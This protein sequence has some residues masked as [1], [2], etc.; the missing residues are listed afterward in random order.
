MSEEVKISEVIIDRSK[1]RCGAERAYSLGDD[2]EISHGKGD[3]MLLNDEGY[4][5]CLGFA[6]EQLGGCSEDELHG[7]SVPMDFM[8]THDDRMLPYLIEQGSVTYRSTRLT[9]SA[10]KYNDATDL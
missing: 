2:D 1:W 8:D 9:N 3:T 4:K 6:C 7:C 10:M 5:C